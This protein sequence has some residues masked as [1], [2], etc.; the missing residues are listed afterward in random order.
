MAS[1]L[2]D[3]ASSGEKIYLKTK[4]NSNNLDFYELL[5]LEYKYEL[6]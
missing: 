4:S 2:R 5:R 3:H 1:D 6:F